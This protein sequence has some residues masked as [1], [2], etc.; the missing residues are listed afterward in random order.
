M[1]RLVA[2]LALFLAAV[3]ATPA[4]AAT[5]AAPAPATSAAIDPVPLGVETAHLMFKDIDFRASITSH[6]ESLDHAFDGMPGRPEW[7]QLMRDSLLEEADHIGPMMERFIGRAFA[8]SYSVDELNAGLTLLRG[9]AGE[10]M[11]QEIA[12]AAAHPSDLPQPEPAIVQTEMRR[13]LRTPAGRSW[14]EKMKNIETTLGSVTNDM[15]ASFTLE[16]LQ[17]FLVRARA[18]EVANHGG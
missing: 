10:A 17:T 18:N 6:L 8:R 5:A 3:A 11:A 16:W 14:L 9:P 4:W 1:N 7:N 2:G 13:L 15:V 12:R